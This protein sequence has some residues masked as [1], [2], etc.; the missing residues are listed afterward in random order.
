[1]NNELPA[2]IFEVNKMGNKE[3]SWSSLKFLLWIAIDQ[4]VL[5]N[6][7]C[8]IQFYHLTF[9]PLSPASAFSTH[10]NHEM[11]ILY[12]ISYLHFANITFFSSPGKCHS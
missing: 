10:S 6:L 9:I 4:N 7:P 8:A 3:F 2:C 1:M 11:T 12:F 5:L